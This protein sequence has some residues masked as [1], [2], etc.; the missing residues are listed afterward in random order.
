[1]LSKPLA[2]AGPSIHEALDKGVLD[3]FAGRD[4][5]PLDRVVLA[6][7]QHRIV[8][9]LGALSETPPPVGL[10]RR[11]IFSSSRSAAASS[12]CSANS[13]FSLALS[14]SRALS[15]LASDGSMPPNL[16]FQVSNAALEIPCLP[17]TSAAFA[18]ASRSFKGD[19][20]LFREPLSL[21]LS[22]TSSGRTLNLLEE[23]L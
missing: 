15:R 16:G 4:E 13:F 17:P 21:H 19:N 23:I 12:I 11:F 5:V 3:R 6:R 20:L 10:A 7:S 2:P 14:S 9:E 1:M 22:V 18:L 8:G